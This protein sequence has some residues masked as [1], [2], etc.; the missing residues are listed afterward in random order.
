MILHQP[1]IYTLDALISA[2]TG[3]MVAA[4]IGVVIVGPRNRVIKMTPLSRTAWV[5]AIRV[6]FLLSLIDAIGE[7]VAVGFKLCVIT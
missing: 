6:V 3:R 7:Q 5:A 1:S 4:P 2:I